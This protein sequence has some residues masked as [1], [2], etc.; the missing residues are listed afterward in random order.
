MRQAGDAGA[1][2]D[3]GAIDAGR[4]GIGVGRSLG[5]EIAVGGIEHGA[6]EEL[7]FE[8]GVELLCLVHAHEFGF[9]AEIAGAGMGHL[10]PF[11]A[12]LA[13]GEDEPARAVQAAGLAGNLLKFIIERDGV[14]LQLCDIGIAVQ[15]VEAA[16]CVPC[17]TGC[18]DVALH[19]HHIF[20]AGLG[21]VIEH[22]TANDA[23]TDDDNPR[24]RFHE[25]ASLFC[26]NLAA[27]HCR[28]N[29][30]AGE[31]IWPNKNPG[32]EARG[33]VCYASLGRN[34]CSSRKSSHDGDAVM[35]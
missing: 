24:R 20:P 26:G 34:R 19:Q 6:H 5:I 31:L 17:G 13:V 8:Q 3:F 10:Q 9:E 11:H 15:G 7:L 4:L 25:E 23:A 35:N 1:L 22:R 29:C 14:A 30:R 28:C 12:F 27:G 18:Q 32:H 16:R 2:I 21:E 33:E